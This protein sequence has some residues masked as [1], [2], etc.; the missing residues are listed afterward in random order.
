MKLLLEEM[1]REEAREAFTQGAMVVLPTGSIEQHGPHLPVMVDTH[2]VTHVARAAGERAAAQVPLVVT[3][4]MH[5]G[6]S[7]HH[8]AFAG[9]MSLTSHL[10]ME[11]IK[12]L[13]RCLHRHGVRQLLLI[14]GHG[15]NQNPNGVI[16]HSLVNEEGLEMAVGQASYWTIASQALIDAGAR[17]V[18]PNFPGHAGGFETSLML[19]LRPD[20]VQLDQRR[21]PRAEL[22]SSVGAVEHGAFARAG[23]TSDDAS[24]ADAAA[25]Q[26]LL[27]ATV[28]AVAEYF[29][30]FYERTTRK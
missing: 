7:H 9:T 11:S 21:A 26:K 4:T 2:V 30:R 20:L 19:A 12:E 28:T 17:D 8:L 10:Y 24:R 6:V 13:V 1:T 5:F 23:G 14:N 25:G 16:A 27:D 3:P 22:T 15:G 29:V 18:A